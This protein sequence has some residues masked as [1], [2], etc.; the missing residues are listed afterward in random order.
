MKL[1]ITNTELAAL[2]KKSFLSE[3]AILR[4]LVFSA[5]Y[6][7]EGIPIGILF[8][9]IPG[10]LAMNGKTPTE[11]ASYSAVI[12]IPWT[13]KLIIAPL[14]DRYTF[15]S[16]GRKRPWIIFGQLGLMVSFFAFG[17][18]QDPLDNLSLLM[19][20]GFIVNVFGSMQDIAIDGMAVELIPANQQAR[21][22]GIMWGSR[23]IGQS[24]SLVIGT[25]LINIVGFTNA[26]SSMALIVIIL[27]L[28]PIYFR[29]HPGEKLMPWSKGKPSEQSLKI[30]SKNWK[31]L[32]KSLYK[33]AIL[34]S[35]ILLCI[36]MFLT[37][38]LSG[39]VD[40]LLPIFTV[41]QLDWT[42]ASYS[43]ISSTATLVGG[44]FGMFV[45][46][47]II[48]FLGTKK[49][50]AILLFTII[51]LLC[52][53]GLIP[54]LWK[55]VGLIYGFV[56]LYSLMYTLFTIATF[57]IAMKLSWEKVSGS[58][59]TLYMTLNNLGF[60]YGA[61]LLGFLKENL[62]WETIL[63]IIAIFPLIGIFIFKMINIKKN[64]KS[65]EQ[66][67]IN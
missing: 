12:I 33:V 23:I 17:F 10:W 40:T 66:F 58:Q 28:V 24:L 27:I 67:K 8:Y 34:P 16:M 7:S 11:I 25:A 60:A 31:Q 57:A 38:A 46:G 44:F 61:W 5:L 22:N 1:Q 59:F 55:H 21:A 62:V 36:G 52:V 4:Y 48:D 63:F 18:I 20:A 9:A 35:S 54:S 42:N 37:G 65:I 41:Q 32:L 50:V 26:I 49:M 3:S 6:V 2:K 64:R 29:E 53:F 14:M 13:F 15:I 51:I 56:I 30:Q 19:I 43:Y 45:G 39:L 47:V